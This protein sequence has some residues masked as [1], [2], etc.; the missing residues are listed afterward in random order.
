MVRPKTKDTRHI[1]ITLPK[2]LFDWVENGRQKSDGDIPRSCFIAE[3]LEKQYQAE[4][5]IE[6]SPSKLRAKA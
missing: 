3:K 1:S 6:A 5:G 4:N 2:R